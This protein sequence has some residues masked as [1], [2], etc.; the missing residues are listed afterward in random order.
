LKSVLIHPKEAIFR[1]SLQPSYNYQ[2]FH[3]LQISQK[4]RPWRITR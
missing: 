2:V 1:T 3:K 4:I